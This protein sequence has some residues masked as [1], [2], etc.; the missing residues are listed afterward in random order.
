MAAENVGLHDANQK[1]TSVSQFLWNHKNPDGGLGRWPE[2]HKTTQTHVTYESGITP[3]FPLELW[4]SVRSNS[5]F[6]RDR[7][8]LGERSKTRRQSLQASKSEPVKR[9][10]P[11]AIFEHGS[12]METRPSL[13]VACLTPLLV[14]PGAEPQSAVKASA[15]DLHSAA[16][17]S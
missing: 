6:Q 5:P 12:G 8:S 9:A 16:L 13:E 4:V 10:A 14:Y 7:F 15:A 1:L 2:R 3:R 17:I 11:S